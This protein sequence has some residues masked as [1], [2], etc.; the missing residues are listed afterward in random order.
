MTEKVRG[1]KKKSIMAT[2]TAII[3]MIAVVCGSI[4]YFY[5]TTKEKVYEESVSQLDEL[6][7]QLLE[8]LDVQVDQQWDKLEIFRENCE[9]ETAMTEEEL[10]DLI[11]HFENHLAP[12]GTQIYFRA[13]DETGCYYTNEGRQ[14]QWSGL[15]MLDEDADRQNFLL[16]N[17]LDNR[18]FMAFVSKANDGITVDGRTITN[19]VLLRSMEDM[20]P[21][22]HS[23][24]FGE[25]N[26]VYIIDVNGRIL[27]E[28]GSL[29]GFKESG[30]NIF[31]SLDKVQFPHEGS[32]D[33]VLSEVKEESRACTDFVVDGESYY[34][35]Y[36]LMPAYDWGMLFV[37]S[38]DDV[39]TSTTEM[40]GS[41]LRL[42]IIIVSVML[43]AVVAALLFLARYLN[44]RKLLDISEKNEAKLSETNRALENSNEKLQ[45][46]QSKAESARAEA[47]VARED[48]ERA[49]KAK[50]NFLSN[51]SHDIRTPMNA[52]VGLTKLMENDIGDEQ[53]MHYYIDKLE[54]S[55]NYMLGLINDILDKSKIDSGEVRLNLEPL[56]MAEQ[57]GQIESIIRAQSSEKDQTLTV[58]VHEVTHE[59]LIGD[60]IR[61][62]QIFINLLNN[63]VKYTQ[64]GGSIRFEIRELPC[65]TQGYATIQ[66]SV[67]DNGIGMSKEYLT[68]IFDP[69]TR[70]ESSLTN[71]VQG[72]GLGM[73]I[74]KSLVDLMDG[75]IT[76]ESEQ[77]KGTRFDVVLTL[78]IDTE[79]EIPSD[80]SSV[81]LV[82]DDDTL[83][84][85]V[86]A[87]LK[88]TSIAFCAVA[89]I[90]EAAMALRDNPYDAVLLSGYLEDEELRSEV[91]L[92]WDESE[93]PFLIFCC[94]YAH[95]SQVMRL[96]QESGIDG[97]IARPFFLENLLIAIENARAN[98]QEKD[99]ERKSPLS[100]KR[101][102]CA[103]DIEL[104][105]EILEA[106]LDMH[107]ASCKIYPTGLDL[108]E[109]FA[110]VREGDYDAILM[111]VQMPKMD[112]IQATRAIR[113]S[114]NPLGRE[115]PII[116]MTANAFSSDV[117]DCLEAGMDAHLAKPID[118]SA[119]ERTLHEILAKKSGGWRIRIERDKR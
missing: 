113:S 39:A 77:G 51:M 40:V 41:M 24:S 108:V 93:E 7:T 105:A 29:D 92:L 74:T 70:E 101:F 25:Q 56:K 115:I 58:S 65:D 75:T 55:S 44:N 78:P 53:K 33:A 21:Y 34:L 68:Y 116:A 117:Q 95:R 17:W 48:A 83:I 79:K 20:Q 66:T 45:E 31:Y 13:I 30:K 71:K 114:D 9:L 5:K 91:R 32:L 22:F 54:H 57:A 86:Q 72:T 16:A 38:A 82:T 10:T 90:D 35:L 97:F 106:I 28:D 37:V 100:G 15:D 63:A 109:A 3:V 14:G 110:D 94:D 67:I 102:L 99:K 46:A 12:S 104:N 112:G 1:E 61:I 73:S 4:L 103:E 11:V 118:I 26:M 85:N 36:E 47:E 76:V 60:S 64:N 8:K 119:L 19:F 6:C 42:V 87:A 111:D 98:A 84:T 59:Y 88:E 89:S 96:V 107:G 2:I 52:I 80:L 62:R 49:A 50:S 23:S 43:V 27:F 81:L 69:F 18:S